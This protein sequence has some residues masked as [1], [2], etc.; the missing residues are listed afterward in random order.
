MFNQIQARPLV[1]MVAETASLVV[2]GGQY[3][4]NRLITPIRLI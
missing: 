4:T 2:G 1:T 3:D